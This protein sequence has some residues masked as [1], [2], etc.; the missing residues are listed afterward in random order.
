MLGGMQLSTRV[1]T[2]QAAGLAAL[3]SVLVGAS[4][5]VTGLLDGYP[6]LTGQAI[7]YTIGAVLL[8]LWLRG[9]VPVPTRRGS[10]RTGSVSWSG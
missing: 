10:A 3:A 8:L 6:V 2:Q 4:V 9:R 7:R 5:P 1:S